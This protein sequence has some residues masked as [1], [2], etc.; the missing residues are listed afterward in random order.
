MST[1]K[2]ISYG[3]KGDEV[4]KLQE[5][6]N[7]KGD[8]NLDI[9]GS[10]GPATRSA[11][12]NYQQ[13]NNLKVDGIVG[14]NTWG[15][16]LGES[17]SSA[18]TTTPTESTTTTTPTTPTTEDSGFK[19]DPY[20]K[21]DTVAQAEAILQQQ[22]AQKPGAYTSTWNDQLNETISQILK[23]EKF[24][25][26]LNEDPFYQQYKDQY[27][28]LG[29]QASMDAMG[30][31]AAL[32]GGYGNSYAQGVGQ[33]A[34]QSYLQKLNEVV[35]EL[36]GMARDQHNQDRQALYDQASLL[37]GMEDQEYGR[38]RDSLSDYYAELQRLTEDARYQSEQ[39]YGKWADKLNLEY[40]MHRDQVAD[41]QWQA[42]FDEAKRQ[43]D[44]QYA[45]SASKSSGG[46]G[47]GGGVNYNNGGYRKDVVKQAQA[48]VGADP[49]GYWG[50]KSA[51][52]AKAMNF[53]S[54]AEV[55]A[56][57]GG[58]APEPEPEPTSFSTYSE[59]V[60]YAK[61]NGVPNNYAS[62]IYDRQ[63]FSRKKASSSN[64]DA[65]E[66][67]SYEEYLQYAVDSMIDAYGK[68]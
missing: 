23:G 18:T 39:D 1:Y 30:Q 3:A 12:K 65:K 10:F 29:Q 34:Y 5:L 17:N 48:F 4:K 54:L 38:Y 58:G 51:A 13:Q 53:N 60:A 15:S 46:S 67:D 33:Q 20:T 11:V 62:S 16:L 14:V 43:F 6:L 40:G 59:A 7:S 37:A 9:D 45:L 47:G 52:A 31:A 49:D 32:T 63:T 41:S 50:S 68:K 64:S 26:D 61:A 42:Q 36:Y 55:V 22:L 28:A 19:Y 44:Q 66:F 21:S 2:E 35:P 56:A 8:Y 24:S 25:Y 27:M 57:M